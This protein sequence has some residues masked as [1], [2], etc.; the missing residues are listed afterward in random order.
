[1]KVIIEIAS[2][3]TGP[4]SLDLEELSTLIKQDCEVA[5]ERVATAPPFAGTKAEPVTALVIANLVLA[6]L[7]TLLAVLSF[8]KSTHPTYTVTVTR[9][10]K[11]L[12]IQNAHAEQVPPELLQALED[13]SLQVLI[14]DSG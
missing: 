3:P 6:S 9:G 11:T 1:M 7:N 2:K 4:T 5:V 14:V 12:V 10:D 8:W 13:D